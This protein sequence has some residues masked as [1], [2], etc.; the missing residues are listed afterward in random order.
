[1][2]LA[3][4]LRLLDIRSKLFRFL[5]CKKGD[6]VGDSFVFTIFF[7][8]CFPYGYPTLPVFIF[9]HICSP[10]I[11]LFELAP[12]VPRAVPAVRQS[13]F[14]HILMWFISLAYTVHEMC[15]NKTSA[16]VLT[17]WKISVLTLMNIRKMM[18]INIFKLI[19]DLEI[20]SSLLKD[21][22]PFV[23]IS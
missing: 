5:R 14:P 2:P 23:N 21:R 22:K 12:V 17:F 20:D 1:M 11:Y 9:P 3:Q 10:C 8:L 19:E 16:K 18:M 13:N 6:I 15:E 7:H 4:N